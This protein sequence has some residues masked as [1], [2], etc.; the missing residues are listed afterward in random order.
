MTQTKRIRV[1]VTTRESEYGTTGRFVFPE[2]ECILMI[3][4]SSSYEDRQPY[5]FHWFNNI[6]VSRN[7]SNKV[8]EFLME[9][10]NK[11][12]LEIEFI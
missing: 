5:R 4:E 9:T 12:G 2:K 8:K 10:A 6:L 11:A 1:E 7:Y 3:F